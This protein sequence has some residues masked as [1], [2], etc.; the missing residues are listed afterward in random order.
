VEANNEGKER[1][2]L[3][4]KGNW[5]ALAK[6]TP[7]LTHTEA[8]TRRR[9]YFFPGRSKSATLHSRTSE[10]DYCCDERDTTFGSRHTHTS[11]RH[12]TLHLLDGIGSGYRVC[13]WVY[14]FGASV[15]PCFFSAGQV[16]VFRG[17]LGERTTVCSIRSMGGNGEE[18]WGSAEGDGIG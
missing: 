10:R 9:P 14:G 2:P 7:D 5:F 17:I 18:G 12:S 15:L 16:K 1:Q 8:L 3:S 4:R 6:P 13:V 11:Y